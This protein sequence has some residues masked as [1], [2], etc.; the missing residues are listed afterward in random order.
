MKNTTRNNKY[1]SS[2]LRV[3]RYSNDKNY[4]GYSKFDALNSPILEKLTRNNYIYR[5][6]A[7]HIVNRIPCNIRPILR[8]QK[9]RNPKGIA[10]FIKAYCNLYRMTPLTEYL[11][12][13]E[14]LS[15][16]LLENHSNKDKKYHG[17]CWGY[18]S[19]W[20]NIGFYAPRYF[21]NCIVTVFCG[22][23]LLAAYTMT[24]N[25]KYLKAAES[26]ASFILKDLPILEETKDSKCIG[27]VPV[28]LTWKVI[29]I[30]SVAAGFLSKL[31]KPTEKKEYINEAKKLI[32]W[33]ILKRTRYYAWFYTYPWTSSG[34][35]HDNYHTGGILDG[36]FDYMVNSGDYMH[37]KTYLNALE[38]YKNNIFKPNG[39]PKWRSNKKLPYDIHGVAQGIL[40]FKKASKFKSSYLN[41]AK[42]IA[43]WGISHMQDK[44]GRFYYKNYGFFKLKYCL[45][46]WNNSWM[47]WALSSMLDNKDK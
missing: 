32:N 3:L 10:N 28:N 1:N 36:I 25:L 35:G 23:A 5:T 38:F 37:L 43:A 22:E 9:S 33:V 13:I 21:P 42:K 12:E 18:N 45:M 4:A 6:L 15:D 16:W 26:A 27:Y 11:N 34:I 14:T 17:I 19:P 31:Y 41:F 47:A 40:T 20:Q 44:S 7:T 39:A 30:N 46:R 8:V 24:K 2:L 29:N